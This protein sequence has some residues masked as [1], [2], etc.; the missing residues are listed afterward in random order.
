MSKTLSLRT[1]GQPQLV[2]VYQDGGARF[3]KAKISDF[4]IVSRLIQ[5]EVKLLVSP[6]RSFSGLIYNGFGGG[7]DFGQ[8]ACYAVYNLFRK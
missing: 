7:G 6:T 5:S 8:T 2:T 4:K 3:L 1:I